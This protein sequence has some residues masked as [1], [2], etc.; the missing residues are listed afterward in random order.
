MTALAAMINAL[1]G[2]CP[3]VLR[4]PLTTQP[5]LS[6]P[7]G[8]KIMTIALNYDVKAS[9]NKVRRFWALFDPE[10]ANLNTLSLILPIVVNA[11]P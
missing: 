6:P 11:I 5:L 10:C 2:Q 9:G 8:N 3:Y 7:S 1:V 4:K